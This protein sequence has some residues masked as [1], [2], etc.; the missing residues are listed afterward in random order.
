[1]SPH[2]N[3]PAEKFLEEYLRTSAAIDVYWA[4]PKLP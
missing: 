2:Q 1:M 3:G 4:T